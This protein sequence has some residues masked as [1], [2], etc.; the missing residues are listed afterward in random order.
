MRWPHKYTW[1]PLIASV[2]WFVIILALLIVWLADGAPRVK[3]DNPTIAYIS[4]VGMSLL[5]CPIFFGAIL[6]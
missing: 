6:G 2:V 1:L 5:N 3:L 4:D